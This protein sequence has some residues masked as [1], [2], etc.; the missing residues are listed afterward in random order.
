MIFKNSASMFRKMNK[1]ARRLKLP[2][3][4]YGKG[5]GDGSLLKG[6]FLHKKVINPAANKACD[7]G[8]HSYIGI[9]YL[10]FPF[11]NCLRRN[12]DKSSEF[13]L[14]DLVRASEFYDFF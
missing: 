13:A 2:F 9:T 12:A 5:V 1:W 8:Q 4:V 10:L 11:I 7:N 6:A 3:P 14:R